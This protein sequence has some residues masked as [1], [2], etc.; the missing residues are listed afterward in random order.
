MIINYYE[1]LNIKIDASA[2]NIKHSFRILSKK[3]H[4]D[5][6]KDSSAK[7]KFI[8]IYEAYSILIDSEKRNIYNKILNKNNI[9]ETKYEY[10]KWTN[11]AKEEAENYSKKSYKIFEKDFFENIIFSIGLLF[12]IICI[13]FFPIIFLLILGIEAFKKYYLIAIIIN[14]VLIISVVFHIK[15]NK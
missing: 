7:N 9:I 10:E 14:L 8:L 2:E 13:L 3:Y 12:N 1:I 15:R 4:P 11:K 6:N 5:L